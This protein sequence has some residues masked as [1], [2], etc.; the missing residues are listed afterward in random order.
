VPLVGS[1]IFVEAASSTPGRVYVVSPVPVA[2]V[3]GGAGRREGRRLALFLA[4]DDD[5]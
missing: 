2:F 1:S 5:G 4:D 3:D